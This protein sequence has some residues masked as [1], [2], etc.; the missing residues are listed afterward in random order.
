ME[1]DKKTH[2]LD[3]ECPLCYETHEEGSDCPILV[4]TGVSV[5]PLF[6]ALIEQK[7]TEYR[8]ALEELSR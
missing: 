1:P 2:P 6:W 3:W 4:R 5:P 7:R 8:T